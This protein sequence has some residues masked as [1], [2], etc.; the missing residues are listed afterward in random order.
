MTP[1]SCRRHLPIRKEQNNFI[2]NRDSIMLAS[3]VVWNPFKVGSNS[4]SIVHMHDHL[5]F[6]SPWKRKK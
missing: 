5:N 2:R 1:D 6:K 4:A 3:L